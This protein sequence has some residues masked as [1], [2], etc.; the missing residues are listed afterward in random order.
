MGGACHAKGKE[1]GIWYEIKC[2]KETIIAK[3]KTGEDASFEKGLLRAWSKHSGWESATQA[4]SDTRKQSKSRGIRRK[5]NT[6]RQ[7]KGGL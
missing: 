5:S 4:L 2:V 6:G 1:S 7:R 3:E